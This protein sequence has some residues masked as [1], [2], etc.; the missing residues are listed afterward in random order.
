M[1]WEYVKVYTKILDS[2]IAHDVRV[3]HVFEDLLK[4]SE[5]DGTVDMTIDAIARRTG[6]ERHIIEMAIAVLCK[7]DPESRTSD[8]E[9]RRLLALSGRPFGW[10]IVNFRQYVERGG[11]TERVR[12]YRERLAEDAA[13]PG[14]ATPEVP[15]N[16]PAVSASLRKRTETEMETETE[17]S[18]RTSRAPAKRTRA[19]GQKEALACFMRGWEKKYGAA[20]T[21]TQGDIVSAWRVLAPLTDAERAKI[22]TLFLDDDDVLVARAAHRLGLLSVRFDALRARERGVP[23]PRAKKRSAVDE[24]RDAIRKAA[25]AIRANPAPEPSLDV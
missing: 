2:S 9:G 19:T 13:R 11:S 4:L 16:V 20:P 10:L 6:E 23:V 15:G 24:E 7:P 1:G 17:D 12:R 3:R 21:L 25:D 8:F 14:A 18:A 22:V 5:P